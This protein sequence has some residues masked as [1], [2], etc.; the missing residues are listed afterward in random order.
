MQSVPAH[1]TILVSL[2]C[3]FKYRTSCPSTATLTPSQLFWSPSPT[4]CLLEPG[5]VT[6]AASLRQLHTVSLS[7]LAC[8]SGILG[9]PGA[10][11]RMMERCRCIWSLPEP[12]NPRPCESFSY[13]SKYL[14]GMWG[15][16][17]SR[18]RLK[19]PLLM[20][21]L[22][23]WLPWGPHKRVKPLA[24][25]LTQDGEMQGARSVSAFCKEPWQPLGFGTLGSKSGATLY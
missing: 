6:A 10:G 18:L 21:L 2:A 1:V 20:C 17:R 25:H 16:L 19:K 7:W 23:I 8:Q 14:L 11:W 13:L 4:V 12:E 3:I 5:K 24:L 9:S 22:G 15:A